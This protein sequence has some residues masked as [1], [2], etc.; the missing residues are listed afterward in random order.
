M[1]GKKSAAK[2]AP[3]QEQ[4][5]A[6]AVEKSPFLR[7]VARGFKP[8]AQFEDK[9]SFLDAVYGVRFLLSVLIGVVWGIIPLT[10]VLGLGS[11]VHF[12]ITT[13]QQQT[14]TV[15][16]SGST[17]V[18]GSDLRPHHR[19][20][21]GPH[22]R[23]GVP[24]VRDLFRGCA[25]LLCHLPCLYLQHTSLSMPKGESQAHACCESDRSRGARRTASST[26]EDSQGN[27]HQQSR[28]QR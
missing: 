16:S 23:R 17:Q 1:G 27:T 19:L 2:A 3:E 4:T 26:H 10:G 5:V 11:F 6:D 8:R 7:N 9:D 25:A 12:L 18:R 24:A 15:E 22:E 28:E 13:R 20:C 14:A 21:E